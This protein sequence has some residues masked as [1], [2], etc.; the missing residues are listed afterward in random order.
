MKCRNVKEGTRG[1]KFVAQGFISRHYASP[2][3][4][5]LKHL[6]TIMLPDH[7]VSSGNL[8]DLPLKHMP[9]SRVTLILLSSTELFHEG[10]DIHVPRTQS[11]T[12]VHTKPWSKTCQASVQDSKG[13]A[14]RD[15]SLVQELGHKAATPCSLTISRANLALTLSRIR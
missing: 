13:P 7:Q 14:H 11:S 2:S 1:S 8:L 12:P 6:T 5:L 15:T 10:W 3:P 4:M 9:S